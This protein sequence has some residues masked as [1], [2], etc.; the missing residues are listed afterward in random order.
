MEEKKKS[1]QTKTCC[2]CCH[3]EKAAEKKETQVKSCCSSTGD[4]NF[5]K[6]LDEESRNLILDSSTAPEL[7][8]S[9]KEVFGAYK[10]QKLS[11]WARGLWELH[12]DVINKTIAGGWGNDEHPWDR[13]LQDFWKYPIAFSSYGIPSLIMTEPE[14]YE[15]ACDIFRKQIQLMKDAGAYDEW[16]RLEFGKDPVTTKNVMYKGHLML[17]YGLYQLIS[18]STEFEEEYHN[19]SNIILTEAKRNARDYNFWGIECEPDQYFPPCNSIALLAEKVYDLNFGTDY[20]ET[21]AKPTAEFIRKKLVDPETG[22]TLYRYHPIH[23]Y[24]EPYITCDQAWTLSTFNYFSKEQCAKGFESTKRE[25]YADLKGGTECYMKANRKT[26][27][28]STDYEQ[29]TFTLYGPLLAREHKDI[30]FYEKVTRFFNDMYGAV[31]EDGVVHFKEA[32]PT[33][34][35]HAEGYYFLGAVHLGFEEIFSYDWK[36]FRIKMGRS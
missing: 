7:I 11:T 10:K 14:T 20:T 6:L 17:M 1:D 36:A 8:S 23:D 4:E 26:L 5:L 18:G 34:E 30:E 27:G 19:L 28:A 9:G 31:L 25:F 24:A 13:D 2:C 35:T 33:I 29:S 32:A 21:V 12:K 3:G 15:E 16:T 22:F